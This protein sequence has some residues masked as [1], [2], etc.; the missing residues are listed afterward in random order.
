MGPKKNSKAKDD[1]LETL[2]DFTSKENWDKFF[3]IRG[4]DDSFEWYAEWSQLK[5]PLISLLQSQSLQLL[6]PGCG[7]SRLSEYLY[8]AGF[9]LIT[10]IDFS[11]VVISD[12]LR[13]NVR[14]RPGM[15]WRVMDMTKMQFEDETFDAV[16][17]K[18]GLDALME[19]ELGPKLGNQYLSEVKRV[20]KPGGKFVCLTLGESHVLGL[21]F[22]KFRLGWKMSI[23]AIPLKSSSK[24]S[25]QTFMVVVEKELST[26]VH[27]ITSLLQN[28]SL[29][30]NSKQASGLHEALQ[31]ENQIRESYSSSSDILYSL[32][33]LQGELTKLSQGRRLQLTL[34]GQGCSVF[35]YG[36][37]VLDAEEQ[38]DPFTYHCGVFIVPKTRA[39]EWLFFS[40]E[41]QWMVVRSSNAARLIM[42]F[43]DNSHTNASMDEIQKDLSPLV[44]ELAPA[45]NE[46]G[47]QIPFMMASEGIKER[48][49]VH[50]VT[51][52]LTGSIVVE[53]VVYENV[54]SEVS[55]IFPSSV[56]V[57]RR[58]VFERAANLV[59]SEALLRDDQLRTKLVG[60]TGMK[61]TNSSKSRKSGSQR[62]NDEASKQLTV[63]HGY[64]ASSYHT[65]II[66]GFML[67]SSYMESVA[68][69]GK[70]VKAVIIGLGAGL[71]P[72]FLHGCMPF[73]EIEAVELDPTIVDIAR[74]HFSFVED[75][76]LKVHIADGIQF[77]TEAASSEAAQI[78]EKSNGSSHT[79]SPSNGNSATSRAEDVGA[80]TVDIIIVDVDSSD[81]SSGMTC[82]APDFIDESFLETVKD[83]LSEHGLF[84][85]N[86]VSRSQAIKDT[87]LLRMKKVFSHLF[88]L[89]LDEDV[90]EVHFALKS[91]SCIDDSLFSEASLKLEKLLKFKHPE[92]GQNIINSTKKIK[93]LK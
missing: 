24:S 65:G 43:L 84:V 37:V 29:H 28:S 81:P 21:L 59:Q 2:G 75:K 26:L 47:A 11:K 13:R 92:I 51:S 70:M 67:I 91:A 4:K 17:D 5:N 34:G 39:R 52:S 72:M 49:N 45:E 10:N 3:S 38:S 69:S 53:D 50:Q 93:R 22:S 46:N 25:L 87:V 80:A 14:D 64:L 78:L 76:R 36:A 73:L 89:Q 16:I 79:E 82:P 1:I 42:V 63:Y 88:S 40:E 20:L 85:V 55:S 56:L 44:K 54:D 60:E 41:G 15:R 71:L 35:S 31:T 30:S 66:S 33:D 9:K 57:F 7:N 90:N 48:N 86:L 18:G 83:K 74:D 68:S 77:V 61:K 8:D 58:L 62:G 19:P 32:E 23:S 6:V 12:M 27:Q